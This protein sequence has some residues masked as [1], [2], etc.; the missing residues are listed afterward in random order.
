MRVRGVRICGSFS[1][2]YLSLNFAHGGTSELL[3]KIHAL[4][5]RKR[6]KP[7]EAT[8]AKVQGCPSLLNGR[9]THVVLSQMNALAATLVWSRAFPRAPRTFVHSLCAMSQT[10]RAPGVIHVAARAHL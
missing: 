8:L 9:R 1:S 4:S 10:R 2:R 7:L 3:L 5:S 6:A